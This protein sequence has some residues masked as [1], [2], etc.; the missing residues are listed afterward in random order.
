MIVAPFSARCRSDFCDALW[1][2][3][4]VRRGG[5]SPGFYGPAGLTAVARCLMR[6][7][8]TLVRL[9]AV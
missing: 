9:A 4:M 5:D 1:V 8:R 3:R 6:A 7:A 2:S